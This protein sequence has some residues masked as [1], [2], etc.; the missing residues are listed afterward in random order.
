MS[1]NFPE[2]IISSF[3][4]YQQ[5]NYNKAIEKF[6]I[7]I[8]FLEC[9]KRGLECYQQGNYNK[10][11]EEFSI[12]IAM[13]PGN[14][15]TYKIRGLAYYQRGS[16]DKAI[17]DFSIV[18][19]KGADADTHSNLGW[20]YLKKYYYN[21]AKRAFE[22]ALLMEPNNKLAENGLKLWAEKLPEGKGIFKDPRDGKI[23]KTVEIGTQI[24]MAEN[25]NYCCKGS[26][27]NP[28]FGQLYNWET[29][30]EACPSGW[31]LPSN[32]EWDVLFRFVDGISEDEEM[33]I[34]IPYESRMAGLY[35]KAKNGWDSGREPDGGTDSYGFSA[36][37]G[38]Y[39]SD[40]SDSFNF[41]ETNGF[42]WSATESSSDTAYGLRIEHHDCRTY[43]EEY[44]KSLLFSVRCIKDPDYVFEE[45]EDEEP[46]VE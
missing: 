10:A 6:G 37:P 26:K 42:W 16:Y 34:G 24:W 14:A 12:A 45:V 3:E 5:G 44:S 19:E 33:E 1:I 35:L 11:I 17:E 38:G 8:K 4:S 31:H 20:A 29:A 7:G 27:F 22:T 40:D 21:E 15:N 28:E 32:E 18:I 30:K 9:T 13:E 39:F 41:G 36:L 43:Q 25:L 23:Y 46:M 2:C